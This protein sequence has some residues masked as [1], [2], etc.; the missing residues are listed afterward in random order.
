MLGVLVFLTKVYVWSAVLGTL[1]SLY[2][3]LARPRRE[4]LYIMGLFLAGFVL[5]FVPGYML[6]WRLSFLVS[7]TPVGNIILFALAV[8][9]W[10][11]LVKNRKKM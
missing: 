9:P 7:W 11:Y 2:R 3:Y 5:Y 1:F 10:A 4:Y 6:K 8:L